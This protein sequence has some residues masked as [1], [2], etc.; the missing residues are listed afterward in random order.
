MKTSAG[1]SYRLPGWLP[2]L[3]I[4]L[5]LGVVLWWHA[6][7]GGASA[8]IPGGSGDPDQDVW[9]LA[10]ALHALENGNNPFFTHAL[11]APQGVNLLANPSIL[12][13]GVLFAPVT[14]IFGPLVAFNVAVTVAP[15][16]SALAAFFAIRRY[17]TWGPAGFVGGLCYG[18]GPFVTTDL[19]FGHLHLTFLV[20]PPLIFL[21]LDELFVRER[22]PKRHLGVLLGLLVVIQF[23]ISTELLAL[24]IIVAIIG[25]L[26]L[27]VTHRHHIRSRARRAAPDVLTA[28]VVAAVI[29]AYPIWVVAAGPRHITGPVFRNL[30]NVTSTVLAS[31]VPNGE[32]VGV[33]FVSGGN[34]AYL[35]V[36]LLLLLVVALWV[37]RRQPAL[38]AAAVMAAIAYVA[39]LGP[40]LYVTRASTG[41]PL[42]GRLLQ[43]LPL[44]SSIVPTRFGVFVDFFVGT[45]LAIVLDRVHAGDFGELT[46]RLGSFRV[47]LAAASGALAV[48]AVVPLLLLPPWP[49]AVRHVV[50]PSVF[51]QRIFTTLAPG[52]EVREYP[53]VL[54]S[55][56]GPLLWQAVGGIAYELADGYAIVPGSGG[57]STEK[58]AI[59]A[60]SLVFAASALGTLKTPLS[61]ST[62]RA[63]LQVL[64]RDHTMVLV[65]LPS[66][67]GSAVLTSAL[68]SALGPPQQRLDGAAMWTHPWGHTGLPGCVGKPPKTCHARARGSVSRVGD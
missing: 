60:I 38:R 46:G 4:Y 25:M 35:G 9:F 64:D 3:A 1:R 58:P 61:A 15:A 30:D 18:F 67:R 6:W 32:R 53:P 36:P 24:T 7:S 21:V 22:P 37:W 5:A 31:V 45:A 17:A 51:R 55:D 26:G 42:P 48:V 63:V 59:D 20:I 50:E 47:P 57:I 8:S 33:L 54:F 23:F 52:S 10:W 16:A 19:R 28:F 29:L 68:T 34:G 11:Y 12:A 27:A 14:A 66:A 44:L 65:V 39:S 2:V 41:I 56:A 49:Y 13:L 40:T 62:D 43:H